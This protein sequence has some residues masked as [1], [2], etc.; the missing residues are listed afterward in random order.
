MMA[1]VMVMVVVGVMM[2][3]VV[4]MMVVA[5]VWERPKRIRSR[6]MHEERW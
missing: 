1:M 6:E 3:A 5:K 2:M 4:M